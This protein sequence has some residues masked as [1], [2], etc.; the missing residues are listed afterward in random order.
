MR[1]DIEHDEWIPL[2]KEAKPKV[3]VVTKMVKKLRIPLKIWI[4]EKVEDAKMYEDPIRM[5]REKENAERAKKMEARNK[6]LER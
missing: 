5:I 1:Y 2:K 3:P 6:R 4:E